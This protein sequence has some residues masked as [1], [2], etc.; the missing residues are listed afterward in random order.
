MDSIK[1]ETVSRFVEMIIAP[2]SQS[3]LQELIIGD[4]YLESL[5]CDKIQSALKIFTSRRGFPLEI[6]SFMRTDI[7]NDA[8]KAGVALASMPSG[9]LYGK[10]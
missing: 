3:C 9:L 10:T 4:S 6:T 5:K 2:D 8:Y 7:G 1:T